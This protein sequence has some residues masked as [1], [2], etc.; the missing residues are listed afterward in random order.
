MVQHRRML[1]ERPTACS[2]RA[3]SV[4][5]RSGSEENRAMK[6]KL[7]VVD[8]ELSR[9]ARRLAVMSVVG[10]LAMGAA[11]IAYA[12]VPRTWND[13][14]TLTAADLNG[15]FSALDNRVATLEGGIGP[16]VK[17]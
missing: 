12:S 3:I 8:L 13:G 15:N 5:A 6:I 17:V 16:N 2:D 10:A 9:R 7:I 14:D 1:R 11:A 4:N